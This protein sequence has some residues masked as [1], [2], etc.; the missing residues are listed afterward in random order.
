MNCSLE[1]F[2]NVYYEYNCFTSNL[3]CKKYNSFLQ[4]NEIIS[5]CRVSKSQI[6]YPAGVMKHL[7]FFI[8]KHVCPFHERCERFELLN[9]M[10]DSLIDVVC[11][12][13]FI[14]DIKVI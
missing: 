2:K 10:D 11:R 8:K 4:K 5:K 14:L 7:Q 9:A 12:E 1:H 3:V 13:V 6:K